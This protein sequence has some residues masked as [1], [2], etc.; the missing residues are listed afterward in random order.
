M[1]RLSGGAPIRVKK[2]DF[3]VKRG[4]SFFGFLVLIFFGFSVS[5][6]FAEVVI[7]SLD[8][9]ISVALRD[10]REILLNQEKLNQAVLKIK[11]AQGSFFPEVN[12]KGASEYTRGLYKKDILNYSFQAGLK[13]YLYKGGKS[14]NTLKQNQYKK[15]IQQAVLEENISETIL[16]VKKAFWTLLFSREFTRLNRQILENRKLHL[17]AYLERYNKGEASES[18]LLKAKSELAQAE[19][20]YESSLNQMESAQVLLKNLLY[21]EENTQIEL[22]GALEYLPRE[23]AVDKAILLALSLRPEI[24]QYELQ[25]KSDS[26]GVEIAKADNRPSLFTAFDYYSKSIT[27][28]TFSP[29]K[30]WQDYT[31]A[32]LVI[33]WPIFDGWITK[34]KVEQALSSLK[35]DQITQGQL[36]R[37]IASEVQSAYL[38][39]K[40][41]LSGLEP[42]TRDLELGAD[43]L[44]TVQ[45]KYQAGILSELDLQDARTALAVSSFNQEQ[46][47][48][49][50]V[51]ARVDLDYATGVR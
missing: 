14:V 37:D 46:A 7:L 21:L 4:L 10:N 41:S 27:S 39:L 17:E 42:K 51:V 20:L 48:Y 24:K 22:K 38:S 36:S 30:G 8:E 28:L 43:A 6:V 25:Q 9:A 44:R 29:G 3:Q 15:E 34:S 18:D 26:L 1:F 32:A 40:T 50:C 16:R 35:Q 45:A 23:I 19:Y 11:E 12:V 5:F 49:E 31:I 47:V 2:R 33:S 13:H